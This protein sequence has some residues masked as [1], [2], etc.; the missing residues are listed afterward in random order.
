MTTAN[1]LAR[2]GAR[3]EARA[4]YEQALA[5][6]PTDAEVLASYGT[7]LTSEGDAATAI[8]ILERIAP[9]AP[10]RALVA[11]AASYG[12]LGRTAEAH[13]TSATAERL[14]P[15]DPAVRDATSAAEAHGPTP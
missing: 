15:N 14:Y 8:T 3:A 2:T 12:R 1:V 11:L 6:R 7:F 10:A 13:A 4:I 9:P 5:R